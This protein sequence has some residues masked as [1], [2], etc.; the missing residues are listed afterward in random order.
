MVNVVA[1]T[2]R[3]GT[4]SMLISAKLTEGY[5]VVEFTRELDKEPSLYSS[6]IYTHGSWSM[7]QQYLSGP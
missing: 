7:L 1:T 2:H 3:N 5:L 6:T 4:H